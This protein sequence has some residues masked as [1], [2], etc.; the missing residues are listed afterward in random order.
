VSKQQQLELGVERNPEQD[1]NHHLGGRSFYFFDFD[2]NVA[3]LSTA[4]IL[5]ERGT[6]A[7]FSITSQEFAH[8][9]KEIG[10]SGVFKNYEIR[11]DDRTGTFRNFRDHQVQELLLKGQNHQAFVQDM[12]EAL[13]KPP[14]TWQGP[15]WNCF[16][17]AVFNQRP[18]SVITARGHAPATL[19]AGIDL[20]V[21]KGFLPHPPNYLSLFPVN[22][23]PTRQYLGDGDAKLSTAALKQAAIRKSVEQALHIYG[24]S[25][26]HR[27]GMSDDDEQNILLIT[28]E[29]A[30]LKIQYPEMG[31]FV[32]ETRHGQ[33]FKN[34]ILVDSAKPS[35]LTENQPVQHKFFKD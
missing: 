22:H 17:H 2:D 14:A 28:E 27:F 10:V 32:I 12:L 20:L 7:E 4:L 18:L 34:E 23:L 11:L 29:L 15:S 1:R 35:T 6:G 19:R 8:Q 31:F 33:F 16:Y 24:H 21:E 26:H 5:F 13:D 25:A 3:F 30:R 9:Q